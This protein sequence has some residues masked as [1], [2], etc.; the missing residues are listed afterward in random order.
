[1][2]KDGNINVVIGKDLGVLPKAQLLKPLCN[3]F[4]RSPHATFSALV[5]AHIILWGSKGVQGSV[6]V[7]R[8]S[9]S[10]LRLMVMAD[11]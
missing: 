11:L 3:V 7:L 4:H 10:L 1:M 9:Q 8:A 6:G 5:V 2:R